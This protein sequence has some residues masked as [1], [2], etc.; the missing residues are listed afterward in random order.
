[1]PNQPHNKEVRDGIVP[2]LSD[3]SIRVIK[4]QQ[5]DSTADRPFG[6]MTAGERE[7]QFTMLVDVVLTAWDNDPEDTRALYDGL[8]DI[9]SFAVRWA[10]RE[11]LT[12]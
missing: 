9:A 8:L 12:W 2:E 10:R 7:L 1:M 5:A 6:E 3:I 4:A 11:R